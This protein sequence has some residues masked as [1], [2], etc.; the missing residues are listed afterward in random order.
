METPGDE[1]PRG[2]EHGR[3]EGERFLTRHVWNGEHD[4]ESLARAIEQ[5]VGLVDH[6][7]RWSQR[8]AAERERLMR[9]LPDVFVDIAHI[10]STPIEGLDAKPIIDLLA[11]VRSLETVFGLAESLRAHG[12]TSSDAFNNTIDDRQFFMRHAHGERT[13]HLHLVVHGSEAWVDRVEFNRLLKEDPDLRERYGALKRA[14]AETH[15]GDREAY[16]EGK[17]AFIRAAIGRGDRRTKPR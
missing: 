6:D 5:S 11:G 14:L 3:H 17:S 7:P 1:S 9:V 13:H 12:Y 4:D 2:N 15:A 8:F 10:G 16:T